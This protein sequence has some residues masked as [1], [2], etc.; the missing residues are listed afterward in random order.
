MPFAVK[1]ADVAGCGGRAF[2]GTKAHNDHVP[3]HH[4][5]RGQRHADFVRIA[6]Q[7]LAQVDAPIAAEIGQRLSGCGIQGKEIVAGTGEQPPLVPVAPHRQ[8]ALRAARPYP[9]VETPEQLPRRAIQRNRV[10][11]R[12]IAIDHAIDRQ[13]MG[14]GIACFRHVEAPGLPKL[15]DIGTGD[16]RQCGKTPPAFAAINRPVLVAGETWQ[17][18][19]QQH[20]QGK[21]VFCHDVWMSAHFVRDEVAS[22]VRWPDLGPRESHK[23]AAFP[24]A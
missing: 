21:K 13:R 12:C 10:Q 7:P 4:A 24:A 17:Q 6:V 2:G 15:A 9:G 11:R 3:P 8:A 5:R 23:S 18:A 16:L 1:G 22:A 14:L 19:C 20:P